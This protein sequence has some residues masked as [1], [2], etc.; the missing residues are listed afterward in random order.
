MTRFALSFIPLIL[1]ANSDLER[2]K[3]PYLV[4]ALLI[5]PQLFCLALWARYHPLMA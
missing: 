4:Y 3:R 1:V 2:A 5:G